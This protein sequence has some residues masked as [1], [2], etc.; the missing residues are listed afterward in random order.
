MQI[1]W[2]GILLNFYCLGCIV[3]IFLA[4]LGYNSFSLVL[5]C[6][7]FTLAYGIIF[8]VAMWF[9]KIEVSG[10]VKTI[11]LCTKCNNSIPLV[12]SN[13]A[14]RYAGEKEIPIDDYVNFIKKHSAHQMRYLTVI[15]GP[16]KK[17]NVPWEEP[18]KS[19]FYVAKGKGGL[20]LVRSSRTDINEPLRYDVFSM[21]RLGGAIGRLFG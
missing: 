13:N 4:L 5:I 8:I 15:L 20:F 14:P 17:K 7:G 10:A 19:L 21:W 2:R 9:K 12:I 11:A 3:L 16:W 6:G 18:V 1:K